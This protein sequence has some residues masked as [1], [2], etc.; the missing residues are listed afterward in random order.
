MVS[1]A[2]VPVKKVGRLIFGDTQKVVRSGNWHGN[3]TC[4][5]M[6]LD[7][8]RILHYADRDGVLRDAPQ[9]RHLA[10]VDGVVGGEGDGPL[11]P[12]PVR[13][14]TLILADDVALADRVA[15]R[16]M[17]YDPA[18]LPLI[19]RAFEPSRFPITLAGAA[20]VEVGWNG[21]TLREDRLRPVLE[22]PFRPPL[23][24]RDYL[25]RAKVPKSAEPGTRVS[26]T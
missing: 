25:L 23:G 13:A 3:D 6:A 2:F 19:R 4:W 5:R 24:W 15:C 10:L 18:C 11:A 14:G 26:A 1:R 7:L 9:R 8:A 21:G 17:G 16:L 20:P 12:I 22:R